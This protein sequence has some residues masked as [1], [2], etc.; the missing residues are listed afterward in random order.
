MQIKCLV[1]FATIILSPGMAFA[2]GQRIDMDESKQHVDCSEMLAYA[3][4]IDGADR[5]ADKLDLGVPVDCRDPSDNSTALMKAS[6]SG[7][8][9]V[10]RVLIDHG[11]EIN[12]RDKYGQTAVSMAIMMHD[13]M[14]VSGPNFAGNVQRLSAIID[15]L[16]TNHATLPDPSTKKSYYKTTCTV[17][18]PAKA[19]MMGAVV[20]E[21][22]YVNVCEKGKPCKCD[23]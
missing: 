12:A 7:S 15:L 9:D 10:V 14:E 16:R 11:A 19:R 20:N 5:V 21:T 8:V 22:T 17:H 1:I 2:A 23:M 13:K 18:D 4:N 6:E 3:Y